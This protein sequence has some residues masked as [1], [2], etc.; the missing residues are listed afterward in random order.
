M[1]FTLAENLVLDLPRSKGSE[2]A[3]FTVSETSIQNAHSGR[4]VFCVS[5][6]NTPLALVIS[7]QPTLPILE[8]PMSMQNVSTLLKN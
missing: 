3:D 5:A 1:T 6:P 4:D 8:L 2:Q 7:A